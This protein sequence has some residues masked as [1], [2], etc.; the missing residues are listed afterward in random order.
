MPFIGLVETNVQTWN[1]QDTLWQRILSYEVKD[2][3]LT[4]PEARGNQEDPSV[5]LEA[6]IKRSSIAKK[7]KHQC[8]SSKKMLVVRVDSES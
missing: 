8:I 2:P 4:Y 7:V 1:L 5:Q 6:I 3:R